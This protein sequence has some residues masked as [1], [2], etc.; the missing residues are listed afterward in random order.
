MGDSKIRN[1][2]AIQ[3]L[4]DRMP[5]NV[6]NSFSDDQ[7]MA[8]KVAIGARKW[9][10]HKVDFRGTFPMPFFKSKI[11]YV[12]LMGRN[13]REL[14]RSE[15]AISAFTLTLFTSLFILLCAMFGILVLYL[16]KSALGIDLIEGFSFG[17]WGW[18]KDLWK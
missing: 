2:T 7:L 16:V 3:N 8:L 14:T 13:H 1:E 15:K 11:Y 5:E 4:L 18:F 17:V 6:S 10:K 9:G 12:F